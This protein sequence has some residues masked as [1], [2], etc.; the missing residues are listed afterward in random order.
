MGDRVLRR[1][2]S[3]IP[4]TANSVI[5]AVDRIHSTMSTPTGASV[6]CSGV[7]SP[8]MLTVGPIGMTEKAT[9]AGTVAMTGARKYTGLSASAAMP[10]TIVMC[11]PE[12]ATRWLTPVRLKASP[13]RSMPMAR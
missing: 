8:K 9:K 7:R 11:R 6:S 12:I 2:A 1:I 3:T 13:S 4:V 5:V 10:A